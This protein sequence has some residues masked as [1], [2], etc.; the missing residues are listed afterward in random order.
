MARPRSH[1][2]FTASTA[3]LR[4]GIKAIIRQTSLSGV[5]NRYIDL[6]PG[7]GTNSPL[8]P[9][10]VLD[11]DHTT[12]AVDLDQAFNIF[13]PRQRKA[14][15]RLIRGLSLTY[16]GNSK[17]ANAGWLYLSPALASSARLFQALHSEPAS[18]RRFI[19]DNGRLVTDVAASRTSQGWSATWPTPRGPSAASARR[20]RTRS[21]T[22]R[23]SCAR[24]TPPS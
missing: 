5:A 3:P 13:G 15:S 23:R 19:D 6:Q 12:S 7:P 1:S 17:K 9:R 4:H 14:L 22:C 20:Y 2:R 21:S 16:A 8:S 10:E 18:L 24:P 11:T